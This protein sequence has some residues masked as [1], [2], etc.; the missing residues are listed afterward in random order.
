MLTYLSLGNTLSRKHK[1]RRR[2][3][4]RKRRKRKRKRTKCSGGLQFG[5][6]S[7]LIKTLSSK[8]RDPRRR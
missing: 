6:N 3:R 7:A 8:V 5:G 1:R 2:R 4:G